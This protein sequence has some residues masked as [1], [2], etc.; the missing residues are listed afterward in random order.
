MIILLIFGNKISFFILEWFFTILNVS[1]Y[2][3]FY[4]TL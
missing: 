1:D 4:S 2:L 3:F